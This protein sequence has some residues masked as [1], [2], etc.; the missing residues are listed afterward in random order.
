VHRDI[1]SIVGYFERVHP[2]VVVKQHRVTHAADDDGIWFLRAE[3]WPHEVQLESS[4]GMCPFTVETD[5]DAHA[6]TAGSVA[7]AIALA[8]SLLGLPAP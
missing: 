5:A 2:G 8:E 4:S 3:G 1:E 6:R 7:A